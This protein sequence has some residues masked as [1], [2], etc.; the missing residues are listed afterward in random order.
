[1]SS[2]DLYVDFQTIEQLLFYFSMKIKQMITATSML[3]MIAG[4]T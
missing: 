2:V 4:V 1:M 3:Q